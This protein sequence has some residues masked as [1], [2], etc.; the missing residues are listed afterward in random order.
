MRLQRSFALLLRATCV[1]A[2][3]NFQAGFLFKFA[4]SKL[5]PTFK[6]ETLKFSIFKLCILQTFQAFKLSNL[7]QHVI[8]SNSERSS[9]KN[10]TRD[11]YHISGTV[12][13]RRAVKRG[14]RRSPKLKVTTP[15]PLFLAPTKLPF[16]ELFPRLATPGKPTF[17]QQNL[18][19]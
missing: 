15:R 9:S 7:G 1:A 6:L 3:S 2:A 4:N 11:T 18:W 10:P 19:T 16:S 17:H 12:R 13:R 8:R 14:R 5:A